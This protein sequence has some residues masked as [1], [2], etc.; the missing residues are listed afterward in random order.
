MAH[1]LVPVLGLLVGNHCSKNIPTEVFELG[2]WWKCFCSCVCSNASCTTNC[3]APLAKVIHDNFG[4]EEGLM[5]S[6]TQ[7]NDWALNS[8][9]TQWWL[10]ESPRRLRSTHTQ[11]L[12]RQWMAPVAR[13]GAMAVVPIRTSS[14]LPPELPKLWARSSL[15][16]M[17]KDNHFMMRLVKED[18]PWFTCLPIPLQQADRHG[19]QGASG[20]CV[21][22]GPDLPSVQ[23]CVLRHHQGGCQDSSQ[24]TH[25]GRVRLHGGSGNP[26]FPRQFTIKQSL[27]RIIWLW[28]ID[29]LHCLSAYFAGGLLWLH[30][31]LSLLHLWC[32]CRHFS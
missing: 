1:R 11:P 9:L 28:S 25:E 2:V 12:R 16:S 29:M 30:W 5:V 4:I 17:G 10:M 8:G 24:W 22:G 15:N 6:Q 3:L 26:L 13:L 32:W 21:R 27:L 14:P 18:S 20:W 19:L 31:G 7:Q 23:A